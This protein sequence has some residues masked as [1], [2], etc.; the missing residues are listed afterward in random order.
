MKIKGDIVHLK[1]LVSSLAALE[2]SDITNGL[3]GYLCS[4]FELYSAAP[5][6]QTV[7]ALN[8]LTLDL[9]AKP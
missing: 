5:V 7:N 3:P 6:I 1:R 2:S 9:K 8:K 4:G